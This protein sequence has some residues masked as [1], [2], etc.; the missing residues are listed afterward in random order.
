VVARF[1]SET[2]VGYGSAIISA[3]N[4]LAA[5]SVFGMG[6]AIVR[7][8]SQTGDSRKLINSVFT[9]SGLVSLVL[10][11]MFV[12][13]LDVWSPVLQF[14]RLNA[15]FLIV[16]LAMVLIS[17]LSILTDS[18]FVAQR[19]ARFVLF[20]S[21]IFS[22][23]KIPLPIAFAFF[24]HTFGVVASWCIALGIALGISLFVFLPNIEP[25]YKPLPT[26]NLSQLRGI[27]RYSSVSYVASVLGLLPRTILPLMVVNILG[28]KDN[29]YFYV[30]WMMASLLFAIPASVSTSLFAEGSYSARDVRHN[31][32]RAIKFVFLLVVPAVLVMILCA[33]WLLLA[34]GEGY[35]GALQLVWLLAL[36]SLPIAITSVYFSLLRVHDRL[37]ELTVIQG[38]IVVA[39]LLLSFLVIPALGIIGIGYVWLGANCVAA[40]ATGFRLRAWTRQFDHTAVQS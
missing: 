29:A 26:L 39:V 34:F 16:F 2:E 30:A 22:L 38:F 14:I 15:I 33:K 40:I 36:S 6:Y 31:V 28:T 17:T 12:A 11:V 4:L 19:K 8:L 18:V 23:L 37:M 27:W 13:G 25:R 21:A 24:L 10:A 35:A 20:K 7:F 1:Y 32:A 5:L 9:A 3:T